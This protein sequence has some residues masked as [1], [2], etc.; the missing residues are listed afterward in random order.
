MKYTYKFFYLI[1]IHLKIY[2]DFIIKKN[3]NVSE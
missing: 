2:P 1:F 3:H